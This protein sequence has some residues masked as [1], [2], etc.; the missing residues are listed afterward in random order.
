MVAWVAGAVAADTETR[1]ERK[2]RLRCSPRLIQLTD[3]RQHSGQIEMRIGVISVGLKAPA[4]TNNCFGV[5]A[6]PKF[7]ETDKHSPGRDVGIAGREAER[8]L[9]MGFSF[10]APTE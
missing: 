7:G 3:V 1:I 5:G 10:P 9:H 6:V 2:A 4:Q 8:L